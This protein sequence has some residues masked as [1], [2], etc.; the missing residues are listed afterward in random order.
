MSPPHRTANIAMKTVLFTTRVVRFLKVFF[1]I[2][3]SVTGVSKPAGPV[4]PRQT[5]LCRRHILPNPWIHAAA[6]T[7]RRVWLVVLKGV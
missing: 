3:V 7:G 6:F 4:T 2:D 5:D 1:V